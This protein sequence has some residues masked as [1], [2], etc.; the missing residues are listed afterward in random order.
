MTSYEFGR[1]LAPVLMFIAGLALLLSG[2]RRRRAAKA[3]GG[4]TRGA[5]TRLALGILLIFMSTV[6]TAASRMSQEAVLSRTT[7]ELPQQL[8][9]LDRDDALLG[10][11]RNTA[12]SGFPDSID[13][14]DVGAYG[15]GSAA[16]I[17]AAGRGRFDNPEGELPHAFPASAFPDTA[18][19]D[20]GRTV[21]PGD[22]GG[23]ARCWSAESFG[24]GADVCAFISATT[25]V[26]VIDRA[27]TD[28]AGAARRALVVRQAVVSVEGQQPASVTPP[29]AVRSAIRVSLPP[30][31]GGWKK[32]Q[33]P[34]VAEARTAF[35]ASATSSGLREADMGAYLVEG[36]LMIVQAALGRFRNEGVVTRLFAQDLAKESDRPIG[37]AVS[38]AGGSRGS[39][40]RCWTVD[41]DGPA[42]SCL[43]FDAE[44]FVAVLVLDSA[45]VPRTAAFARAFASAVLRRG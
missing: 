28:S 31:V 15:E 18:E 7:I 32:Q 29:T 10:K 21:P 4:P 41:A 25:I 42:M 11:L 36:K 35:I 3:T 23:S 27:A 20:D 5:R 26:L 43:W 12:L 1:L 30:T 17:V 33:I 9:G 24:S 38:V 34:E 13:L 40:T 14:T 45:S 6:G 44:S 22:L 39:N 37:P 2:R 19:I 16:L 8:L